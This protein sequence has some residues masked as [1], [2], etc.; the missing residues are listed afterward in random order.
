MYLKLAAFDKAL[1]NSVVVLEKT[2]KISKIHPLFIGSI[3]FLPAYLLI[4]NS[5]RVQLRLKHH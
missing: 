4:Q 2:M 1:E 3:L 5:L